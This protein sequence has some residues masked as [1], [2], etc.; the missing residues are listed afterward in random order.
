MM[1]CLFGGIAK[2]QIITLS[3][4]ADPTYNGLNTFGAV[5]SAAT[6]VIQNT[7][8]FPVLLTGVDCY[9]DPAAIGGGSGTVPTL[10]YST[11]SLSGAPTISG[12]TWTSLATG[13]PVTL[14]AAGY[15]N[16]LTGLSF[17]IPGGTSIRFAL[18][19]SLGISYSGGGTGV[20]AINTFSSNGVNFQL[21]NVLIGGLNVGYAG[22][23]P[24]PTFNP[25]YFTGRVTLNVSSAPCSGTPA[26]G[27]T[28]SSANPVC[29]TIGF[30][31]TLQNPTA[32][33]GV[34][35]QWQTA[36]S[37][38]GPWT[39]VGPNSPT[40][41]TSQTVATF[42]RCQVTCGANTG[43]STPVSVGLSAPSSCYCIPP[44]SDC[45]DNDVITRVRLSTL[46]NS[47]TCGTGPPLG[48]SNFTALPAPT[49]Y[50]NAPNPITL[51]LPAN[52][53]E[54]LAV[55][56]DYNQNGA[57]EVAEFSNIGTKPA[58]STVITG[59]IN[60]PASAL[61][62]TT[63]MRIRASF[64]TALTGGQAC[65]AMPTGFGETEDYNVTIT[66]CVPISIVTPPAN[67]SIACGNGTTFTVTTVGSLPSYS[68]QY[69]VN[70]ASPWL[71][72]T[73]GGIYS[74]A[75]TATLTL[76]NVSA[77]FNGYQYRALVVGGCSAVDFSTP[78][79]TLTVT[80]IIPVVNPS[81]PTICVGT[82]QQ[83]TL[84]NTVSAPTTVVFNATGLPIAI[85]DAN[86]A[87][88]NNTIAVTGIPANAIV[89]EMKVRFSVPA[90]TWVGDLCAV[91]RA[92]PTNQILNLDYFI[93]GTGVS[94]TGMVNT[95]I[96]SLG[97]PLLSSSTA[98]Y[99]GTF[100][101]DAV[102]TP[103]VGNPPSGPTGFTPTTALWTPLFSPTDL[104]GNYT[105]A[106]YD[107]FGGD[108]GSLTAWSLEITYV[109][110][111][112]AQGVWTGPAGTMWTNAA[113][114]I[115]Y[116]GTPATTIYVNP[117]VSSNYQV[118]FTTTTPCTSAT[119]TVPVTVVNPVVLGTN[120]VNR[121]VCV[122][123][124][125]SFSV[126]ATG[127]P[128][129]YQ[130]Q[131]S[132]DGGLTY[133]N[134]SGATAS[135]LSLS[136]ITQLM[137]GNR[138]RALLSAAPCVGTTTSTAA[139]LTV[140]ALPIVTLSSPDLLLTPGQ[141]TSITASSSPAAAAGG[142]VWNYNGSN[143]VGNTTN[144][145]SGIDI[146]EVGTYHATVTDINGCSN[147][148]ADIV[149]GSEAS[150]RLWIYPNPTAGA[151]QV[152]LYYDPSSISEKRAVYLYNPSGQLIAS[153]EFDLVSITAPYLRMDFDLGR[154]SRGTYV[155]KVVDKNSGRIVSGL[156]VVQ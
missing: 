79:A 21:G 50:S 138:Y 7:N 32:G 103:A 84:T 156:V 101:A 111:V 13:A 149:I 98:P 71:T 62:G 40:Y 23:F 124:S 49:V 82:V 87:G 153:R 154:A 18:Q 93:S 139:T 72:V 131:V 67:R 64:A 10:W 123:G 120:P 137:S 134:I 126:A 95:A 58:G 68:W 112:F 151:F 39:N 9:F 74:G 115:P 121:T 90:H 28:I 116:T 56:I 113:A 33:S 69:R 104:N 145:V 54:Q 105:F 132:T 19:S 122:G 12:P 86:A 17:S 37:G 24:A 4:Q 36:S 85:P 6:F 89:S 155:V 61:N 97:G 76:A 106:I 27:N 147:T 144:T 47:S 109:A 14:G 31:L 88:I 91:L 48:Y 11:T 42:Y 53:T 150:D 38:A 136:G 78:P 142:W 57:F 125:T 2:A 29:P 108:V 59:N 52:W 41:S 45:T 44:A 65:I 55:W 73:N 20:P 26:P 114:N 110:P 75:T 127:G 15:Y 5:N 96:T 133:S 107:G 66:P 3:T 8:G 63:R 92:G 25:R 30:N 46:D 16:V 99:T 1:F 135:T 148:S 100:R 140:N 118:S 35:Y 77:A 129:A 43:T 117:T 22:A 143:I 146:D 102:T 94:G 80:P 141:T 51:D 81:A 60:I 119:T 70:A 130:W 128:I 152:R 34:T 83:L